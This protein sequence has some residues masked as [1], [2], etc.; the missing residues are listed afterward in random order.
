M[1]VPWSQLIV[2][3]EYHGDETL[4]MSHETS[5]LSQSYVNKFDDIYNTIKSFTK[6]SSR[7]A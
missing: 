6:F 1:G 7:L 4:L 2:L 5:S 3:D